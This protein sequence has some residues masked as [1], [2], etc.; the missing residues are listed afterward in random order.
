RER[1]RQRVHPLLAAIEPLAMQDG[2]DIAR[3]HA[4]DAVALLPATAKP[5]G[6]ITAAEETWTMPGGKGGRFIQKEK[7]GPASPAHHLAPPPLELADAD[8]P[9]R[10]GP[11]PPE[12]GLGGGIM[13]DA[14]IAGEQP[15][16]RVGDDV[17]S[18]KDAVLQGHASSPSFREVRRIRPGIWRF[19]GAQ[20][21]PK[22]RLFGAPRNDKYLIRGSAAGTTARCPKESG[23]RYPAT[24]R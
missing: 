20:L 5:L 21:R 16:M 2:V 8:Q 18:G 14:A 4:A 1:H 23:S 7:L 9:G 3:Q 11:T 15:P 6:V 22:V 17:A 10:A 13:D 24:L 19:P 12:K